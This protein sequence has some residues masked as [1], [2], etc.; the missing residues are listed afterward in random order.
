MPR[1]TPL[2]FIGVCL[3][4]ALLLTL[5]AFDDVALAATGSC[6]STDVPTTVL[7]LPNVTKTLGGPSGWVTPFYVQNA[8]AIQTTVEATFFRFRDGGLITCHKT[9]GLEPGASLVDNPNAD[10]DLPDDTQF[11]VVVKSYGAPIVA[12]VNQLQSSGATQQAL[13]YS[14][15][16]QGDPVVYLPN[17]TRRFFGYD[18]PFIVQDLGTATATVSARFI[19]FD[20]KSTYTR[21]FV[22][23]PGRSAVVDP[24]F[25]PAFN[26]SPNSGLVDGTQYGVTLTATQP[27]AVVVN[28]HNEAGAPVAFSHNGIGKGAT[29]LYA[30]YAAKAAPPGDTFSPIVVQNLGTTPTDAQLVFAS[31]S[32]ATAPQTF[33][34]RAIPAGG[35][36]AFDPRF[37]AGTTTPCAVAGATCLGNGEYSLKITAA[38]P[39]AGVVLPNSA[40]TAA[41]YLASREL[42]PRALV[43]VALR[44]IGGPA[45]WSTRMVA[46]AGAQAQLTVRAFAVPSG[47]L[48]ATFAAA[49]GGSGATSFDLN[50]VAGLADDAQY[51]VTIDGGGVPITAIA[52]ERA[53]T[54]GDAFMAYEAVGLPALSS[55]LSPA[56]VRVASA[57]TSIPVTWTQ[58]FA[59][60]VRDQFG[61][62]MP[63]QTVT[64]S[65]SPATIGT[66]TPSG[67]FSAASTA[68]AGALLAT[69]GSVTTRI[70]ITV[71]VPPTVVLG[72]LTFWTFSGSSAEVYTET[73]IGASGTQAV[74]V[75]VDADTSQI[76][77][78]YGRTFAGRPAVYAMGSSATFFRAV[79]SIGGSTSTT[80]SWAGGLC[81]C[82]DPHPDWLFVNWQDEKDRGQLTVIRHELTHVMEHQL[83]AGAFLPTWFDEGN[84][85]VEEFTISG[86]DWWEA[87]QRYRAVSMD[88]LGSLFTLA[89]LTSGFAWSQRSEADAKYEYAVAAVAVHFLR[90]DVGLAG[91]LLI[92]DL[93]A[94]G[95][96]F[97]EAYQLV[98]LRSVADFDAGF[99]ARVRKLAFRWPGV[100]AVPGSQSGPGLTFIAYGLPA[101]TAI[102][103]SI[104]GTSSSRQVTETTEAYGSFWTYIDDAWPAGSYT[105]TINWNGGSTGGSG[106]KAN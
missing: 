104:S 90:A 87:V 42:S 51:S 66:I 74:V 15:F 76:Q 13:S 32:A 29:T 73:T 2:A 52:L 96:T 9:A 98:A 48:K 4:F 14:G 80:P 6:D 8:G 99:A 44:R 22:V 59:A 34:L 65:V 63:E 40:T 92:F 24:D 37:A 94:Q 101:N 25:E 61:G 88:A 41:G 72:G 78:D 17:V 91:E 49:I 21:S 105:L 54:G 79:Q 70:P 103:Y 45:G 16:T 58:T 97:D 100:I 77:K 1:L 83:A 89:D 57:L 106:V 35:A 84:A 46:Y 23:A 47:D 5:R 56:S 71:R 62:A 50:G 81:I 3:S 10:A 20:G 55:M 27:I 26:G 36:Q 30:P 33:V 11:S 102:T 86:T 39:I 53:S 28:A 60:T 12:V 7:Y 67:V 64:W 19:S 85:R 43:P 95:H 69:A 38:N 82:H 18:V 93:M 68:G 75:Q 31:L